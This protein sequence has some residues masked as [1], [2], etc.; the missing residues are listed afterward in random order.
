MDVA[1]ARFE[2]IMTAI[3]GVEECVGRQQ[4]S[5]TGSQPDLISKD[6][7]GGDMDQR[8]PAVLVNK[9]FCRLID[10][11]L[12]PKVAAG[13]QE[14]VFNL[15]SKIISLL[16]EG[17]ARLPCL[18]SLAFVAL[19][20]GVVVIKL[21][22]TLND[23]FLQFSQGVLKARRLCG[24]LYSAFGM[25]AEGDLFGV[26]EDADEE[27]AGAEAEAAATVTKD[28]ARCWPRLGR[29]DDS[30]ELT[31]DGIVAVDERLLSRAGTSVGGGAD[32]GGDMGLTADEGL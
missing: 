14:S 5:K 24:D 30:I 27:D 19:Y 17:G 20:H 3:C 21:L 1:E 31:D 25:V 2:S 7:L 28:V 8:S 16:L 26:Q 32:I 9:E 23:A 12:S 13:V 29:R 4:A 22:S 11:L 10:G 6:A 15:S 18:S